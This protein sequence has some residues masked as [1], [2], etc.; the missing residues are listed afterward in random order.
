MTW[1]LCGER[2]V[3]W[4][5]SWR[6]VGSCHRQ[7]LLM[8]ALPWIQWSREPFKFSPTR[9]RNQNTINLGEIQTTGL[10]L[11]QPQRHHHLADSQGHLAVEEVQCSRTRY[12]PKNCSTDFLAVAV[13]V[14]VV[15]G[16]SVSS[17]HLKRRIQP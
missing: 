2:R 16:L 8:L 15:L 10:G 17:Y 3:D 7:S 11:V 1:V 9:T 6:A 14:G 13:V 5:L 4:S 12:H